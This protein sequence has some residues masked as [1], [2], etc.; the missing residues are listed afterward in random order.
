[1]FNI[2]LVSMHVTMSYHV[3][4]VVQLATFMQALSQNALAF[5]TFQQ[6]CLCVP[7]LS[8]GTSI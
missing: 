6:A 2:C 8:L 4:G 7:H 1:M 3:N 5:L